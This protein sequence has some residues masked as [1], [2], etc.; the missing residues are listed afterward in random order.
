MTLPWLRG[1][2]ADTCWRLYTF[3]STQPHIHHTPLWWHRTWSSLGR[4]P[5]YKLPAKHSGLGQLQHRPWKLTGREAFP[6]VPYSASLW[7]WGN[8]HSHPSRTHTIRR[9][10]FEFNHRVL[11]GGISF[12]TWVMAF[13]CSGVNFFK[14][15]SMVS[16][17]PAWSIPIMEGWNKISGT[18]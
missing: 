7:S 11:L 9:E 15:K 17:I 5:I 12:H 16:A 6:E 8:S 3:S 4:W 10:G 13:C 2:W 18:L 1:E 14:T